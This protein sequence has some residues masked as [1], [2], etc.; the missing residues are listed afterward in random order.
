MEQ[1]TNSN[2]FGM[3]VEWT[4]NDAAPIILRGKRGAVYGALRCTDSDWC[5]FIN[6]GRNSKGNIVHIKG[7]G[8]VKIERGTQNINGAK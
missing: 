8:W 6:L 2:F 3:D 7:N 4:G 5:Y 1:N